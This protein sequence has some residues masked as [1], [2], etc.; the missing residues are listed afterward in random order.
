MLPFLHAPTGAQFTD[1]LLCERVAVMLQRAEFNRA[2]PDYM[3]VIQSS[4]QGVSPV[5]RR[6]IVEWMLAVSVFGLAISRA[7]PDDCWCVFAASSVGRS[8]VDG[9]EP[10]GQVP[11]FA[12]DGQA[13][14]QAPGR[15]GDL[16]GLEDA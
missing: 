14:N 7:L 4:G 12:G 10:R 16:H 1:E 5:F 2:S 6:R 9:S 3:D 8:R 11:V 13:R 15:C